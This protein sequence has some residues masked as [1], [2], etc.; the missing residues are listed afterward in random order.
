MIQK[1][2]RQCILTGSLNIE[3]PHPVDEEVGK[4]QND[5]KWPYIKKERDQ[6]NGGHR[7]E[8][9]RMDYQP[10]YPSLLPPED[11]VCLKEKVTYEVGQQ[12]ENKEASHLYFASRRYWAASS[13]GVGLI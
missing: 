5:Y 6:K 9:T 13:G 7:A 10:N 8:Y 1:E 3:D 2:E 11:L 12:E 4:R